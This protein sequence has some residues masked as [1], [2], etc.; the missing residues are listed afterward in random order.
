VGGRNTKQ[1]EETVR[2]IDLKLGF[3]EMGELNAL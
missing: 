3:A 1:V 2:A